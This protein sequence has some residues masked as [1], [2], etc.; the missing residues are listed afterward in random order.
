MHNYK[1][2]LFTVILTITF[3]TISGGA[4]CRAAENKSSD[5]S[6]E[7]KQF[8][9]DAGCTLEKGAK[10]VAEGAKSLGGTVK[11]GAKKIT[12]KIKDAFSSDETTTPLPEDPN[13]YKLVP[14]APFDDTS[15]KCPEGQRLDAKGVCHP[16]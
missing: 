15:N 4:L 9:K 12:N 3:T 2:L 8:F 1:I 5:E 7:V 6:S 16:I 10:K 14:L 11:E 13:A